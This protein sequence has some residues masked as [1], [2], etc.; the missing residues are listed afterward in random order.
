MSTDPHAEYTW[1]IELRRQEVHRHDRAYGRVAWTRLGIAVAFVL[2]IW[3]TLSLGALSPWWLLSPPAAFV[4]L[5]MIHVRVDRNRRRASEAVRFYERGL[6]RLE[7]RWAGTGSTGEEFLDADH[8]YAADLDLFGR[9]SLFELLSTARTKAG[10]RILA[11]WLREGAAPGEVRS[12]QE[13][14][15]E[16]EPRLDLREDLSTLGAGLESVVHIERIAA[17]AE[18]GPVAFPRW[19]GPT[20]WVLP[21]VVAAFGVHALLTGSGWLFYPVLGVEAAVVVAL[22]R[23]VRGIIERVDLPARELDLVSNLIARL[24]EETFAGPRLVALREKF[25]R[26]AARVSEEIRELVAVVERYRSLKSADAAITI[27]VFLGTL[28][29]APFS[30]VLLLDLRTA[31]RIERWRAKHGSN[32]SGWIRAIGE[33]EVLASLGGYAWEHPSDPFPEITT[34]GR[35]EFAGEDLAHPLLPAGVAVPNSVTLD[36]GVGLLVVSGSNMSGKSTLLRTVGVNVVLALAGAPVRALRLRLSPMRI[37]ATLRIQD[38]L[39]DGRSRFYAEIVRIRDI[40]NLASESPVLFLLDEILHGTNS[41]DRSIGADGIVRGL[42]SR[43]AIGLVTTHDLALASIA[44]GL[45]PQARNVHFDDRIEDG[46]I[47]FDYRMKPGVV[48][49]SNALDLMRSV[50]IDV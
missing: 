6:A 45:A 25:E 17:W 3:I 44:D 50:G 16:I 4:G 30:V 9:G 40:M 2:L 11:D 20:A 31:L 42:V 1:R 24:E 49:K 46:E 37:G 5:M 23:R 47:M 10:E 34:G 39:R 22:R 27:I 41:H 43:G 8:L 13:A 15:R 7:D 14:V 32:V 38:S 18:A 21:V 12:R 36:D 48:Q 28:L 35:A 33:F 26:G 29:I 19:I